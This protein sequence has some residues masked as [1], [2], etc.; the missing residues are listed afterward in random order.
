MS[1]SSRAEEDTVNTTSVYLIVAG[2]YCECTKLR[3]VCPQSLV[4]LPA[5]SFAFLIY[6]MRSQNYFF[7]TTVF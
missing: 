6:V 4:T 1:K 5:M 2:G 7:D 3:A